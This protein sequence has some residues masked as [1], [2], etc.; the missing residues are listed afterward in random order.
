MNKKTLSKNLNQ[1]V[2][3][4]IKNLL[5]FEI[6]ENILYESLDIFIYKYASFYRTITTLNRAREYLNSFLK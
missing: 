6:L 2:N 3:Y 1:I 5:L 4:L